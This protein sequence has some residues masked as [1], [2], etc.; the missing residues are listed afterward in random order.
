MISVT[1]LK[2]Y[3]L[4]KR[5]T[6]KKYPSRQRRN[7]EEGKGKSLSKH[8]FPGNIEKAENAVRLS[9]QDRIRNFEELPINSIVLWACLGNALLKACSFQYGIT[10]SS[11]TGLL[12]AF[13]KDNF[14]YEYTN[15]LQREMVP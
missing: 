12:L 1:C 11:P 2:G 13:A 10:F 7:E 9:E 6:N 14:T 15:I 8:S 3:L 4:A 5:K